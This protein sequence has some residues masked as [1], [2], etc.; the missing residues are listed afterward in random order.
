M[1]IAVVTGA[2]QGLGQATAVRLAADGHEVVVLDLDLDRAR[3]TAEAVD[4]QAHR[5]DVTDRDAVHAVASR[6]PSCAALVNNA[7]I[8]RFHSI[9]D[10]SEDDARAVIDVNVL[11]VVWCTQAFAPL[12]KAGGGGSI[13]NL[14]SGAAWTHSPGLGM[15]PATKSAVESLTRTMALELGPSGIRANAVGPG[16]VVSDGTAANYQGDRASERAQGVPL[17]RV[18]APGDIADVVAFLC[19]DQARYVNGQIIYVDGGITA[20]RAA[21]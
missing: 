3:E 17:G 2:G 9:L 15:Y 12:M 4:G 19:G 6:L 8:W 11:G 16:L 7:G 18:G 5:C 21:M 10:M 1:G 14:S 20:G 13:V